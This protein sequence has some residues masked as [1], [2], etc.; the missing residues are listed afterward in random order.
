[1]LLRLSSNKI[2]FAALLFLACSTTQAEDLAT[3][4]TQAL[5]QDPTLQQAKSTELG[6]FE[7][8]PQARANLLPS[9]TSTASTGYTDSNSPLLERYNT[10][11]YGA[12][13]TQP[14]LHPSD[15]YQYKQVDDKIKS[16]VASYED[17]KQDLYMRLATQ[18][19]AI[20]KAI[21]D[22][23][24]AVAER[25][26]FSQHLQE[27]Q[28][29][30]NAGVI[31]IT[32]VNEAQAKF[33]GAV[34]QEI[35]AENEVHNQKELMGNITGMAAGNV[36][37]LKAG[38]SLQRPKPDDMEYWVKT[39]VKQNFGLQSKLFDAEAA[40]KNIALQKAGHYPTVD[41]TYTTTYGKGA[42]T[43]PSPSIKSNTNSVSLTLNLPLFNGGKILAKTRE[44]AY[45]YQTAKQLAN[46]TR[47]NVISNIRQAYRGII[48]QISQIKALQQS[49]ISSKSALDATE[50]AFD[51]GTRTIVDVL[52]AQ[53][54]LLN[55]KSNLSK[56][57]YDYIIASF[58]LKRYAGILSPQDLNIINSWLQPAPGSKA[59]TE[60]AK[61]DQPK[62]EPPKADSSNNNST[63][64]TTVNNQPVTADDQALQA[65]EQALEAEVKAEVKIEPFATNAPPSPESAVVPATKS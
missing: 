61:A 15:W 64:D 51:A 53:S 45:Q 30:F 16:A 42:P 9:V 65:D 38:I 1:M 10:F 4:L 47:L 59:K 17:A 26:A 50:A 2:L 36:Y 12:T 60:P 62:T 43:L 46:G 37:L 48:T 8:L 21:D 19:F 33:D 6:S 3:L 44:A 41:F 14:I 57:R 29:K 32:D 7:L 52:N 35:T 24:F 56:A 39:A 20:L 55:A 31:A 27:T 49:V 40:K 22:Y 63:P 18:Y 25:K 5:E 13:I 54:D 23:N 58:G 11:S 28:Q 34:A